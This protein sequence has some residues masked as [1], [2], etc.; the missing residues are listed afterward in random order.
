MAAT[1]TPPAGFVLG[2]NLL[3]ANDC[4]FETW[5]G[6]YV[7]GNNCTSVATSSAQAHTGTKSM[8][9]TATTSTFTTVYMGAS[10]YPA[11][12]AGR[13]YVYS[14]WIY[15]TGAGENLYVTW[16][17]YAT[18]PVYLSSVSSGL[19]NTTQNAWTQGYQTAIAPATAVVMRAYPAGWNANGAAEV[20]YIDDCY[21]QQVFGPYPVQTSQA[22]NTPSQW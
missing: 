4:N 9:V 2:P 18:G 11:V 1:P 12:V 15:V 22:I 3:S 16:D 17:W 7:V 6:D 19:I 14:Y 13:N 21:V 20:C 5:S 10:F 8:A